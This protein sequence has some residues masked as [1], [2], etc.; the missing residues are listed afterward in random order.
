M[1][2]K[3]LIL[4]AV[5]LIMCLRNYIRLF[6]IAYI[7][8]PIS[9][10]FILPCIPHIAFMAC[11]KFFYRTWTLFLRA[12]SSLWKLFRIYC[13]LRGNLSHRSSAFFSSYLILC[14]ALRKY[15]YLFQCSF[16]FVHHIFRYLLTTPPPSYLN[17]YAW[18]ILTFPSIGFFLLLKIIRAFFLSFGNVK[19]QMFAP[20]FNECNWTLT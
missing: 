6:L 2:C 11:S 15:I 5:S 16:K 7:N 13:H 10:K 1:S 4:Q 18:F 12:G 3:G 20:V 14:L 17:F 9:I 19:G 8:F